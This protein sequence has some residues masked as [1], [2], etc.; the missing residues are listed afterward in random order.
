[1]ADRLHNIETIRGFPLKKQKEYLKQTEEHLIPLFKRTINNPNFKRFKEL[2]EILLEE[3]FSEIKTREKTFLKKH[4]SKENPQEK[5]SSILGIMKYEGWKGVREVYLEV[6]EEAVKTKQDIFAFET[7]IVNP[8]LGKNFL[9]GYIMKRLDK[10]IKAYVIC[11]F[12]KEEESY[13]KEYNG[14]YTEIKLLH[15]LSLDANVN[16]VGDLVMTF[17]TNPPRGILQRN[18][19]EA[20]TW[21]HI[22][23]SLWRKQFT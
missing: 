14:K 12:D 13:Q 18:R 17:S 23:N 6:L 1:M 8:N 4:R 16:V 10:K 5:T 9:E 2:I 11:P 21:R 19:S 7:N 20:N 22:F 3:L 15:N